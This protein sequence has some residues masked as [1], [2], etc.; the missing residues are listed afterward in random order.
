MYA[1]AHP[2][3]YLPPLGKYSSSLGIGWVGNENGD[4]WRGMVS[5]K[6]EKLKEMLFLRLEV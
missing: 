4:L 1:E 3:G 2:L 5:C 6:S